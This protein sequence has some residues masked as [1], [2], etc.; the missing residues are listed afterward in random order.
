MEKKIKPTEKLRMLPAV[1]EVLRIRQIAALLTE[2]PR[3]IIVKA[4]R[5]ALDSCRKLILKGEDIGST[6]EQVLDEV[7]KIT[8]NNILKLARPKLRPVINATGVVLH[9]NLGR[10]LLGENAR[11][12]VQMAATGYTNLEMDLVT[13]KR[14]S[15]YAAVENILTELTGAEAALVVNNNASA[16]LLALGT[17][18]GGK[19]VIVSRGQL[20]EIGGSFR[21]PDVMVQSGAI[22]V[23]VGSTNKTYPSDYQRAITGET[24]LLLQVHTSNYRIVGFTR[25]TTIAELVQ[26][27]QEYDLPVMSDLGSGFLVDLSHYGLPKEPT[28]QEVVA[29]G[30]DVVTFSGDK[31]L[32]GP[33]AGIIVG[34]K[35]YIDLMKKNP[36]TRA[37]RIDK[38]TV[39]ALEATLREYLEPELA[40]KRIPTLRMLTADP[41]ELERRAGSLAEE[42]TAAVKDL[43]DIGLEKGFS[44]VGGGAMPTAELPTT[45]ITILP[46]YI[47]LDELMKRLREHNPAMIGRA[48]DDKLLLDVRTVQA[49]EEEIIIEAICNCLEGGA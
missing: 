8:L 49:G 29:G 23:E 11:R 13:G 46:K 16:V 17:L 27:G 47:S 9:T 42:L 2:N 45:L 33:Q 20:V 41:E 36:L 12:A 31:L 18:A 39:A 43:A 32:G 25:E 3:S 48:R 35:K 15:R 30:A 34:R 26:L 14:G 22:L 28:V 24:G 37:V 10:A 6:N 7:V 44:R 19:E 5:E 38:F 1:D 21:I 4:V 40:L